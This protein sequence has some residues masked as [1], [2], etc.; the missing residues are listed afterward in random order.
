MTRK[1]RGN[2]LDQGVLTEGRVDG[3]NMNGMG[4]SMSI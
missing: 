3:V 4:F 2:F 1:E